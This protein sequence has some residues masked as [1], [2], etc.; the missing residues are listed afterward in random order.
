MEEFKFIEQLIEEMKKNGITLLQIEDLSRGKIQISL[1]VQPPSSQKK[2]RIEELLGRNVKISPSVQPLKPQ[3]KEIIIS[4]AKKVKPR[5]I[6]T[7]KSPYV[8]Y[9]YPLV[10]KG[11][12]VKKGRRLA[13]INVLG[14]KNDIY[15]E[16]SGKIVSILVKNGMPVEFGQ[17]LIKI[18]VGE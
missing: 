15:S 17:P 11:Q 3:K 1:P 10:K 7:I 14:V 6:S 12:K 16:I 18:E 9:F 5:T 13:K 4:A 2:E 8:G